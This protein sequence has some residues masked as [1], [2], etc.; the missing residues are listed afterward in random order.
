MKE[1]IKVAAMGLFVAAGVAVV[2][3]LVREYS[4]LS[5]TGEAPLREVE[6][7][8]CTIPVALSN[9]W[10]RIADFLAGE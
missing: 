9:E 1:V 3:L 7:A 5:E 10:D 6:T 4:V 8:E 2:G